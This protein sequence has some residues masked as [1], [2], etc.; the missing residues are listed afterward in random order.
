MAQ[1]DELPQIAHRRAMAAVDWVDSLAELADITD[2]EDKVHNLYGL[3][4]SFSWRVFTD[5]YKTN[6]FLEL[7]YT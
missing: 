3:V 6:R 2:T 1:L 4:D 7:N 5:R